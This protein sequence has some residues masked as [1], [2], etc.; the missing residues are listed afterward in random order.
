MKA[1]W[2]VLKDEVS[3]PWVDQSLDTLAILMVSNQANIV[4][5]KTIQ[6]YLGFSLLSAES[7]QHFAQKLVVGF[8][9]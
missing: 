5:S 8:L 4:K 7:M 1:V 3:K 6:K 9:S 2:P